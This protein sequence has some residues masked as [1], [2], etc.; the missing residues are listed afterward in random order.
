MILR[1]FA[2]EEAFLRP[3]RGHFGLAFGAHETFF[4]DGATGLTE[5]FKQFRPVLRILDD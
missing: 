4:A 5:Q 1:L 2:A 3:F